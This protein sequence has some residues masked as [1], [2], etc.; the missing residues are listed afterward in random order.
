M[1][2]DLSPKAFIFL[3]ELGCPHF[4][5][6]EGQLLFHRVSRLGF[7]GLTLL[8]RCCSGCEGSTL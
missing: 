8:A 5:P 2:G 7:L 6:S 4:V 3:D 1:A